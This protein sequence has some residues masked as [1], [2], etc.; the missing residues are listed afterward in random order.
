MNIASWPGFVAVTVFI[1]DKDGSDRERGAAS[2]QNQE[3]N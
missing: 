1:T 2:K 3:I